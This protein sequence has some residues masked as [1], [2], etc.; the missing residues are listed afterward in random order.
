M[1]FSL[2]IYLNNLLS[3][4]FL[5]RNLLY[6]LDYFNN[7]ISFSFVRIFRDIHVCKWNRV[8]ARVS[9][10]A[11]NNSA[12]IHRTLC[13]NSL[14]VALFHPRPYTYFSRGKLGY[15]VARITA[16]STL[17]AHTNAIEANLLEILLH[18]HLLLLLSSRSR[19]RP[20][21]F[22]SVSVYFSVLYV[23]TATDFVTPRM[24][25]RKLYFLLNFERLTLTFTK[26][27]TKIK[28]FTK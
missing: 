27:R 19:R 17:T 23:F 8:C 9:L 20:W 16:A 3:Y 7:T 15:L 22:I 28:F 21:L 5:L 1:Q 13:R 14:R 18:L 11:Q 24:K 2:Q 10:N 25:I 12:I 4:L 6:T 26:I